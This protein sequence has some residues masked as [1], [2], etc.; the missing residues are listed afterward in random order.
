[1][2]PACSGHSSGIRGGGGMPGCHGLSVAMKLARSSCR[3]LA[4]GGCRCCCSSILSGCGGAC[5]AEVRPADDGADARPNAGCRTTCSCRPQEAPAA[6]AAY[7]VPCSEALPAAFQLDIMVACQG[8]AVQVTMHT[9]K[10]DMNLQRTMTSHVSAMWA[11]LRLIED[12][13]CAGSCWD[14]V[15]QL[16]AHLRLQHR[17]H[18][19]V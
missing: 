9:F 13:G 6:C 10:A 8:A 11:D 18:V 16:S 1:M 12:A 7:C 4:C 15:H 2:R 3:C 17:H 14:H 19:L 5:V